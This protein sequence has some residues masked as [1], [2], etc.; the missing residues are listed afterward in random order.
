[1]LH[2]RA[3]GP[4]LVPATSVLLDRCSHVST[5]SPRSLASAGGVTP[6]DTHEMPSPRQ[7]LPS[8]APFAQAGGAWHAVDLSR[9]VAVFIAVSF[10]QAGPG[11]GPGKQA[12]GAAATQLVDSYCLISATKCVRHW[13]ALPSNMASG[14]NRS[15]LLLEAR[16]G[17]SPSPL[18]SHCERDSPICYDDSSQ[19]DLSTG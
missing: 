8:R 16:N 3:S 5:A 11:P 10:R 7:P 15:E 4:C 18:A 19:K 1:M 13:L 14:P 17:A 12:D 9:T 2:P 6:K